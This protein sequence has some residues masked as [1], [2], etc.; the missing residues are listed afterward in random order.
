[1]SISSFSGLLSQL[2]QKLSGSVSAASESVL[3]FEFECGESGSDASSSCEDFVSEFLLGLGAMLS[4]ISGPLL[5][6][7]VSQLCS[8]RVSEL[9]S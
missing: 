9:P 2:L 1:M 8:V 3:L 7:S 6:S 4:L 5:T